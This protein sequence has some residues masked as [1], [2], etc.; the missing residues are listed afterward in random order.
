MARAIATEI[1]DEAT[2]LMAVFEQ[3]LW[4]WVRRV[5]DSPT[6]AAGAA[7]SRMD[8]ATAKWQHPLA[9]MAELFTQCEAAHPRDR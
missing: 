1:I 6:P 8:E 9:A 2:Q 4:P 7:L 3:D 5:G